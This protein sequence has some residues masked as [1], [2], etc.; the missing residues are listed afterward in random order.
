MDSF[1]PPK[2]LLCFGGPPNILRFELLPE[3]PLGG[4]MKETAL[5]CLLRYFIK[6]VMLSFD[7]ADALGPRLE[8]PEGAI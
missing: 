8:S 4:G 3:M 5:G 6:G 2:M 1:P 7:W